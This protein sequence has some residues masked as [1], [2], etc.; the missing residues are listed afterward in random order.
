[1]AVSMAKIYCGNVA[2]VVCDE[3]IQIHGGLGYTWDHDMHL[4]FKRVR[5]SDAAFGDGN[6]HSE[7]VA[8][9]LE[10]V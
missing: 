5:A 4:Y 10:Q 7:L 9:Y 3:G 6:Y 1:V 2:K 8:Q